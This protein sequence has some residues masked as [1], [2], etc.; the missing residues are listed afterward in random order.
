LIIGINKQILRVVLIDINLVKLMFYMNGGVIISIKSYNKKAVISGDIIEF[1]DYKNNVLY[2]YKDTKKNSKGRQAKAKFEDKLANRKKTLQ[3][4]S[5]N[6]RR[7]V[8]CNIQ[9]DSKFIT[10]TFADNI[11]DLK[12]ANYEWKKFKQRLETKIGYKLQYLVVIEFQKRGAIHYHCVMFNLPYI[13]NNKLREIWGNGFV[14]INKIDNVD[15]V[16]A[17]V[18]KY[19]AKDN[20][21]TRLEGEKMYFTSR[22]LKKPVE[23]KEKDRVESLASSLP[24]SALTYSNTFE[25]E[26]NSVFY[27]QYNIKKS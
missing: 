25:N 6:I 16:G 9:E 18:C 23:I 13:Q 21:D 1:Y 12:Q 14:K 22:G 7:L 27:R 5:R 26:Y 2:D 24:V 8:N 4:N 17:Y 10:L 15:N 3:R 19:I 11:T 20:D